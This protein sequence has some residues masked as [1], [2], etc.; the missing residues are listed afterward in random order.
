MPGQVLI[1]IGMSLLTLI[2]DEVP[3]TGLEP[4]CLTAYASET[5]V[6]ANFTTRAKGC[7]CN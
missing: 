1:T 3:G 6:S 2:R 7:K 4:A 5:Y